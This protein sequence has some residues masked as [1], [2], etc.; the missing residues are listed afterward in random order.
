MRGR[1][2]PSLNA[3]RTFEA[4]AR[5]N[6]FTRAAEELNVTQSAASRLVRSLEEYLQVPLFTR[7]SRRIELT[8]Q[9]RFYNELVR[10]S[11]DLIEAGTVEL[12]SSK[13][14]KGTL[15]IGMLPTFGTRWLV[16]R[17]PSFQEA[18]PEISLNIIS[19]DGELDFTKE[20]I[21]VAI[22]F[23]H[24]EWKDAIV[25]PLMGEEIQVVC[26]PK[27][28]QGEH[29]IISY[30]S[31]RYHRLI[32]HSTRPNSWDHWFRSVGAHREDQQW[33]PTLEHFFMVIQAAVAGL[34]VALLPTFL[35]EDDLRSG[36]LVTP[37]TD[38]IAGP[39]AYYL[40]TSAAKSE[41]PRVKLFRRWLLGQL[42]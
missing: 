4:V 28:M 26:S 1:L 20:R 15:T 31:L 3:I 35:I 40:I 2:L 37:F 14:G 36:T 33:G 18:H 19:S 29:P 38:R 8:D 17:L 21:D 16:P 6:S 32:R 11:L 39:G 10:D 27:L 7:Q 13:E 42:A 9:G 12:I 25:D 41:L 24:G 22:R 30:D 23:G 5:Y 34:G